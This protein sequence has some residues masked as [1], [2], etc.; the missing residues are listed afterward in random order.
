M[1]YICVHVTFILTQ[2]I[3]GMKKIYMFAI[4]LAAAAMVSCAGNANK[5]A[6]AAGECT[7]C[8]EGQPCTKPAEEQC[9]AYDKLIRELGDV[10]WYL[11]ETAWAL[12]IPLETILRG[13]L[14][15]LKKRYPEG[16]DTERS[17]N[18]KE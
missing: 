16:F 17:V 15:K 5:T 18:R 13:N 6:E 11:A 12:D 7:E 8:V 3:R 2:K 1:R 14:E 9:A 10:A 4:V